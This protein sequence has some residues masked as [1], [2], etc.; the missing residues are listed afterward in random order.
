MRPLILALLMV[1]QLQAVAQTPA[2]V[3]PPDWAEENMPASDAM[4]K[5]I[6]E[7]VRE[8]LAEED[9]SETARR[10]QRDPRYGVRYGKF[11]AELEAAPG[12][13]G[14]LGPNGLSRQDTS[15]FGGLL[16]LPFLL[17]AAVTGKCN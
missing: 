11:S 7:G 6:R 10:Y 9:K 14:C 16:A 12:R 17:V 4:K 5:A 2:P 1:A 15:I 13:P 3:V 8:T